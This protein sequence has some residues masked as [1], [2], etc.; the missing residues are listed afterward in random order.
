[1]PSAIVV[2]SLPSFRQGDGIGIHHINDIV[3]SLGGKFLALWQKR[4]CRV[5]RPSGLPSRAACTAKGA[6]R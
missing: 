5:L 3:I 2:L 1:M 6:S 4:L